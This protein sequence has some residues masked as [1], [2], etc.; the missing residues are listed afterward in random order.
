MI[1]PLKKLDQWLARFSRITLIAVAAGFVLLVGINRCITGTE[2]AL[3]V[4]FMF[5]V[6]FVTWYMG[7][8]PGV[9]M[10]FFSTAVWLAA[11]LYLLDEF[12]SPAVPFINETFRL[13]VFLFVVL[14]IGSLKNALGTQKK[15]ARTDTLTGM[16]NRLSFFETADMEIRKARRFNDPVSII[17]IDIDNFKLV[18]DSHGHAE[19]DRLLQAAAETI[20]NNIR[21]VDIAARIGG[22]EMGLLL[23]KTD[24]TGAVTLAE[25]LKDKLD[26]Q[27]QKRNW[28]VTFS[29]GVATFPKIH[30]SVD[31]MMSV[32]DR[33]MYFAKKQ[34]KNRIVQEIFVGRPEGG[35]QKKSAKGDN[36][37][38]FI[39]SP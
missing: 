21:E 10:S 33:L 8:L 34:G 11:D 35:V 26:A 5:P 19:G 1:N 31:D 36:V 2:Y 9:F 22:D 20:L 38:N 4:F 39:P 15:I 27:M 24:I 14:L 37:V 17:Y 6:V 25:K 3:S 30:A 23:V 32:A 13:I 16:A 12:S 7:T 28:P 18:N 29:M